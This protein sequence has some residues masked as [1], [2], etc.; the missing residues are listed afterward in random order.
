MHFIPQRL[1]IAVSVKLFSSCV[2]QLCHFPMPEF[3]LFFT[4]IKSDLRAQCSCGVERNALHAF[5]SKTN[6]KTFWS[7]FLRQPSPS[8]F[9]NP[10]P[11][12]IYPR[13]KFPSQVSTRPVTFKN[14]RNFPKLRRLTQNPEN[15]HTNRRL[16]PVRIH[17]LA[18]VRRQFPLTRRR[19]RGLAGQTRN[20]I[21]QNGYAP[22]I[23]NS[24]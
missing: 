22:P 7:E 9:F 18:Y 21:I 6:S 19:R 17:D 20:E 13:R 16:R 1:V 2:Q 4:L 8:E 11:N 5:S 15:F 3:Y 23:G 24:P 12:Y 14:F 10:S